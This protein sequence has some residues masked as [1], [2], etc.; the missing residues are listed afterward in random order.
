MSEN[1]LRRSE[2]KGNS[3]SYQIEQ[4]GGVYIIFEK[5]TKRG[6]WIVQGRIRIK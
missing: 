4:F 5:R 1:S 2:K 6:K 3:R